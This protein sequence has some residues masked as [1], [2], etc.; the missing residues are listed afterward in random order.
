MRDVLLRLFM[1]TWYRSREGALATLPAPGDAPVARVPGPDP[2]RVL[3]L[4]NGAAS[5]WGVSSHDLALTGQLARALAAELGRGVQVDARVDRLL[6]LAALGALLDGVDLGRFDA[7]VLLAG[8]SDAV[9]LTPL[10][11]W[12]RAMA[13]LLDRFLGAA[14]DA[15]VLVIGPQPVGTVST[16]ASWPSRI[17][18]RHRVA[19][20]R[21]SAALAAERGAW[22]LELPAPIRPPGVPGYRSPAVYGEWAA[23][24]APALAPALRGRPPRSPRPQP[25][26]ER[27]RA[28]LAML[29][30]A[31]PDARLDR[32]THIAAE[33]FGTR[34]AALSLIDGEEQ[35][36]RSVAGT[37]LTRMP[38]SVSMC[39]H[40]IRSDGPLVIADLALDPRFADS[41][42]VT[43]ERGLRFY[44]G[45]P[46][47]SP[48]GYR[49]GALCVL[50][51]EPRD[52][53][54]IDLGA[55]SELALMAQKELWA[56][57][58]RAE[59]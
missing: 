3:L 46:I 36:N 11:E 26:E 39:D 22:F 50:D 1:R 18:D 6:R 38:R 37:D 9:T 31:P 8:M 51:T 10:D 43:G 20:N 14:P 42:A 15:A 35:R 4:G 45:Y 19:M 55:L 30:D 54:T 40:A 56:S 5:G 13:A 57:V 2:L 25:E 52:P 16:Y 53:D 12:R 49:V 32:I 41:P 48:D 58:E 17:A 47:E 29:P 23:R 7:V 59:E 34:Y 33:T 28:A 44:A 21:I 24:I 27:Q